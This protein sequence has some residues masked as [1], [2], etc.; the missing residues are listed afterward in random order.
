MSRCATASSSEAKEVRPVELLHLN[1]SAE[2]SGLVDLAGIKVLHHVKPQT[3]SL[4]LSHNHLLGTDGLRTILGELCRDGAKEEV[5]LER[6]LLVDCGLGGPGTSLRPAAGRAL[7]PDRPVV[8]LGTEWSTASLELLALYLPRLP[9]LSELLL[10]NNDL[11]V[12][13][14]IF[15]AAALGH[16]RLRTLGLSTNDALGLAFDGQA[17]SP[18]YTF[19]EA[20]HKHALQAGPEFSLRVL[21]LDQTSLDGTEL[22]DVLLR[23]VLLNDRGLEELTVNG[24][25]GLGSEVLD[26]VR[27]AILYGPP[28]EGDD[29]SLAD[30]GPSRHSSTGNAFLVKLETRG[31]D[32]AVWVSMVDSISGLVTSH[33]GLPVVQR[34]PAP[35]PQPKVDVS[36]RLHA[37]LLDRSLARDGAIQLL[38][39]SR[40]LLH[41][42]PSQTASGSTV[43]PIASGSTSAAA[44]T[45]PS[46][47]F[48]LLDLPE[49]ILSVVLSHVPDSGA[50]SSRQTAAVLAFARDRTTLVRPDEAPS[51][52]RRRKRE[53]ED[54]LFSVGAW[55]AEP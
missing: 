41:A 10:T 43:S 22:D 23:I 18:I 26:D 51:R 6:L 21:R 5:Q 48:R 14:P 13:P 25:D 39:A 1:H 54:W 3:R 15:T 4:D 46:A 37:N 35:V 40:T 31:S 53:R 33:A 17:Y 52:T 47:P 32:S 34:V 28:P 50:L 42:F 38:R 30:S 29:H 49:E 8:L 11:T 55:W 24:N 9:N 45:R 44:T 36:A 19:L 27:R 16:P 20:Y 2:A 12:L 7:V